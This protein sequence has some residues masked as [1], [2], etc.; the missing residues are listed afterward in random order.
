MSNRKLENDHIYCVL[1]G[2]KAFYS[3]DPS[4]W[5]KKMTYRDSEGRGLGMEDKPYS[6]CMGGALILSAARIGH[7]LVDMGQD[8]KADG[9]YYD[10]A[11]VRVVEKSGVDALT[12]WN[13]DPK[14][15][16]KDIIEMVDYLIETRKTELSQPMIEVMDEPRIRS[17]TP[18]L[19]AC[20]S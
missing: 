3:D 10:W 8:I 11:A 17:E 19:E 20:E 12:A 5:T 13:D 18:V 9:T 7:A 14:T 1:R 15:T 6:A 4:R 16:F 2:A